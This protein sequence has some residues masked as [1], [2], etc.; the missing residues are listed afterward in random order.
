MN[1]LI[2]G[3]GFLSRSD[4]FFPPVAADVVLI[5]VVGVVKARRAPEQ[6]QVV[7]VSTDA[8]AVEF[9]RCFLGIGED[10]GPRPSPGVILH[11]IRA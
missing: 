6:Q 2:P 1:P 11:N 4:Q 8:L 3:R 5:E 9:A 7:P 10:A